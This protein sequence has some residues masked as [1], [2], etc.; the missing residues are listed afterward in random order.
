MNKIVLPAQQ[1]SIQVPTGEIEPVWYEKLRAL[2]DLANSGGGGGS[3]FV[4]L[5]GA[6]TGSGTGTIATSYANNLP[7]NK[8]NSGTGASSL[9][10]WR[11]DGTWA[12]PAGGGGMAI[13]GS[14]TGATLG[15]ILFVG[16]GAVL[17]EDNS[18]FFWDDT[19][20]SLNL[21]GEPFLYGSSSSSSSNVFVGNAG[22]FTLTGNI[23]IGI[24]SQAASSLNTGSANVALGGRALQAG[25]SASSNMAIGYQ[26]L[27]GLTTGGGNTAVG[28]GSLTSIVNGD[29]NV[30][31]GHGA[32][33]S[34]SG[35]SSNNLFLGLW[36]G[37]SDSE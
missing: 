8:L 32:G 7:V 14:I 19:N 16:S 17:A 18:N 28:P 31:I 34:L 36:Q 21:Y 1:V 24:G 9:T 30:G 26:S 15:S 29:N 35:T 5:T 10:F 27:I 11:G 25:T 22:N 37:P 12:T 13:G 4:T 20:L 23:N 6:V 33:S 2:V 3:G